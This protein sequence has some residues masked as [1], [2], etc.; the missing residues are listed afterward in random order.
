MILIKNAEINT[1]K[2]PAFKGNIVIDSGKISKISPENITGNFEKEYDFSGKKIF[3]GFVDAHTHEGMFQGEIGAMGMDGNEMTNPVT[4]HLRAIDGFNPMDPS[5]IEGPAGGVTVINT[6]P[7]SANV[8]GGLF[9]A[10]KTTGSIADKMVVKDPVALKI[11]FGENPK[12]VYGSDKKEPGTRMGV[13]A[14]LREWFFKAEDYTEKRKKNSSD[15]KTDYDMKLE[16]LS[17]VLNKEISVHAHCHR[18]DDIVTAIRIADE[19]DIDLVLVHAT[20][21]HLIA[22]YIASKSIPCII[23]PS[24]PGRE[25]PELNNITFETAGILAN[26]G[27][28][29][30]IQSDTFPPL[31]YF[32]TIMCMAAK[33]GMDRNDV[34]KAVTVIPAEIMGISERVG[35]LSSGMDADFTVWSG[36]PLDFYSSIECTFIDGKVVYKKSK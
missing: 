9:A 15:G 10:M 36:D 5:L 4:P 24:L 7:G 17:Q 21:G 1:M 31:K 13:A 34:L 18:A 35:A 11:A 26:A 23:G 28:K 22:D 29:V 2:S 12:S 6:G 32:Q 14:I 16:V 8:I 3:P 20:E 30:A 19:F 27:V 25:K 33:Y